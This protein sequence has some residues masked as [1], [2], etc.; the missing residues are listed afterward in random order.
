MLS[1][2]Q[3]RDIIIDINESYKKQAGEEKNMIE[4]KNI[5]HGPDDS[6]G[7]LLV[8][9]TY[10]TDDGRKDLRIIEWDDDKTAAEASRHIWIEL[11]DK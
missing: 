7:V 4:V 5:I 1:D 9:D 3:I 2:K 11:H 10:I 6:S 8:L